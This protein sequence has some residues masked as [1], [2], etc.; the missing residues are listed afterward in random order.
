VVQPS[1]FSTPSNRPP[2]TA[3]VTAT[4]I[5]VNDVLNLGKDLE[6]SV[7]WGLQVPVTAAG[8]ADVTLTSSDASK[9]LLSADPALGGSASVTVHV[10]QNQNA[11]AVYAQA[12]A[13]SGSVQITASAPGYVNGAGS[14][15][16]APSG[17][18]NAYP[19]GDFSITTL[20][21]DQLLYVCAAS[22]DPATLNYYTTDAVRTSASV[23]VSSSNTVV[24]TIVNSPRTLTAGQTCTYET[25]TNLFFHAVGT[26]STT[27]TVVQP[28][29]FSTPSNRPPITA[30]VN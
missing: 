11:V 12:L 22:L 3:T 5:V 7:S 1:G 18:V 23:G 10:G 9:L 20:A 28:S 19:G 14:V 26:G 21:P 17:F 15:G 16:F 30:T 27:L 8:G 6:R 29:G 4:G 2:I 25:G 13:N 24:G